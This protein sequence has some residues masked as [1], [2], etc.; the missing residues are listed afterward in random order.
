MNYKYFILILTLF[1]IK[2]FS[3]EKDTLLVNGINKKPIVK[4]L[5]TYK[6]CTNNKDIK[7]II[8]LYKNEKFIKNRDN[9]VINKG[10]TS[11][12]YW[13]SLTVKNNTV[14]HNTYYWSFYND[15]IQFTLYELDSL[16]NYKKLGSLSN[17]TSL[18]DRKVPLRCLSFPINFTSNETKKLFLKVDLLGRRNLY[19]P[20]DFTTE[21]DIL[22]YETKNSLS[23]GIFYGFF[24]FSILFN[25]LLFIVKRKR[26]YLYM[27]AY[28]SSLLVFNIVEYMYEAVIFNN[29]FF[30]FISQHSKMYFILLSLFFYTKVF[31]HFTSHKEHFKKLNT[32]LNYSNL[33][34]VCL[35]LGYFILHFILKSNSSFY[36][37]LMFIANVYMIIHFMYLI[38][39][40]FY[41]AFHKNK[42]T[43][44]Y[45]LCNSLLIYAIIIY[46]TNT[47]NITSVSGMIHW[48][49]AAEVMT[50]SI[51][52]LI[53][54]KLDFKTINQN[55]KKEQQ[56]RELLSSTI[57]NAQENER[58]SISENL[59][60]GL[61][62]TINALKLNLIKSGDMDNEKIANIFNLANR[63]FRDLI[64]QI[65]PKEL[66]EIGLY[67]SISQLM[68][69]FNDA[70][71]KFNI[72]LIG[73]DTLL[74]SDFKINSYR[75]FQEL[76]NNVVKHSKATE[77]DI[78]LDINK[79]YFSMQIEDNGTGIKNK[80]EKG[81]GIKNIK[82]RVA[83][84][85]GT[86]YSENLN[87]GMITI[88]EIPIKA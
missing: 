60:D 44:Y 80:N 58:K 56:K 78:F 51:A 2:V 25:L 61:G 3:T 87:K 13:F 1:S 35:Y 46:I 49:T 43:R 86:Y 37:T 11:C 18:Q 57:I 53:K 38:F 54:Y 84:L 23:R 79:E 20:T 68:E 12:T 88:I 47:L 72:N 26:I 27:L 40:I 52:F 4:Y 33:I 45:L 30:T 21:K 65:S 6:D 81:L 36:Y 17:R 9:R 83:Y 41:S 76:I 29:G 10:V 19:F 69:L 73:D 50:L 5:K 31:Q 42:L 63:Q 71:L 77:V 74:N 32:F 34:L 16:N 8:H 59:H 7:Q 15:G 55:L 82:S 67:A 62:N 85:N 14:K 66:N 75:I 28:I 22:F 39:N 70:N 48:G 64:Y 24:L